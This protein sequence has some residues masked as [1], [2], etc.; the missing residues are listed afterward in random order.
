[1]HYNEESWNRVSIDA[2]LNTSKELNVPWLLVGSTPNEGTL[3]LYR[4]APERVIPMFIPQFSKVDRDS[5][6]NNKKIQQYMEHELKRGLYRGIGEF[7]LFDGEANTPVVRR[8]L[9]LAKKYDLVLHARSDQNVIRQL[10]ARDPSLRIL[11]A[12]GGMLVP[13]H[14]LNEMLDRYPRL[15]IE[16]S[17]RDVATSWGNLK[18]KWRKVMLRHPDRF[19]LGSGTYNNKY[20]YQFRHYMSTYRGWLKTLPPVVAERIAFRNGLEL[21]NLINGDFW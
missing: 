13:P 10:F 2:V 14:K 9:E 6:F 19:L 20:W 5:W 17:H 7:F 4:K 3:R 1:M 21:F 16:I 18:D 8:M 12:H 15:W 11:W